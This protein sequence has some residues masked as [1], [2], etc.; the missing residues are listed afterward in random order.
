MTRR[1]IVLLTGILC[2][3]LAAQAADQGPVA[4]WNFEKADEAKAHDAI[5][6]EDDPIEGSFRWTPGVKGTALKLDGYSTSVD[7][8]A[9]DAPRLTGDF[10]IPAWVAQGA[11]AWNWCPVISQSNDT[12]AGYALQVGARGD[13]RLLVGTGETMQIC[14]SEDWVVPLRQWVHV[15]GVFEQGEGRLL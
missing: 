8:K 4:L 9:A 6:G 3:A 2:M 13:V 12:T 1:D 11:Y 15:A 14:K 5:S 10:T 7:R